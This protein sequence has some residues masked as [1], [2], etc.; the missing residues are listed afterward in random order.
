[1][2][3]QQQIQAL[4]ASRELT[5]EIYQG[6]D[7]SREIQ[8]IWEQGLGDTVFLWEESGL[9]GLAICHCGAATEAGS[10]TCYVK[11]GAARGKE[12]AQRFERILALCEALSAARGMTKLVAGVNTSREQ[13]YRQMRLLWFSYRN[14]GCRYAPTQQSRIQSP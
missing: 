3:Q 4:A 11:F 7:V 2:T 9:A 5:D 10:N 6:L 1:M 12:A 14:C 8:S 13:A